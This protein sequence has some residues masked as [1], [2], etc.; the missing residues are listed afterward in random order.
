MPREQVAWFHLRLGDIDLRN[1]R[2][3]GARTLFEDGLA[4]APDD[5]RLLDAMSHLEAVEGNP[6]KAIEYGERG[7]AIKLDPATLGTIGDAYAAL[8]N[9]AKAEEYYKTMEVAVAGQPGAYHRAWSLFLLDHDRRVPE[10][11]ANVQKEIETRKDIYGYDLLGWALHKEHRDAE[12]RDAMMQARRLGTRD[13]LLFYHTGMIERALGETKR[14]P[15][16][17]HAGAERQS[18]LP[19]HAAGRDSRGARFNR[20]RE[21]KGALMS[22]LLTFI[23]LGFRHITNLQ[24]MDHILFL[25]ALAAIYR[26]RDWRNALWVVTAFT[27]GHSI[28][29]ALAVTGAVVLPIKLIEFLIPVTIVATCIENLIVRDRA[30][31]PLKG[32]YR[33]IFAAVFGLVHGAGFADYLRNLFSWTTSRF[34]CSASTLGSSW[35]RLSC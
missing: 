13:A 18:Q 16:F 17:P 27:V 20:T 24:A 9:R 7:I 30:T 22:E 15:L 11:L 4:I 12:A 28:T 34:R 25:L 5:Y 23:Q 10:V 35:G 14:R 2:L 1:G 31:A 19:S 26:P 33:P 29:L 3:R 21:P 6:K 8:G 32:R